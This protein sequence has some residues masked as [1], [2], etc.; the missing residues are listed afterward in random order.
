MPRWLRVLV[1]AAILLGIVL[2]FTNVSHKA[3]WL[4]EGFTAFHVSGYSDS[5]AVEQLVTGKVIANSDL[6]RFQFPNADRSAVDTVKHIAL[7][8][9]ELPPPYFLALRGWVGLFGHTVTS[10]RLFSV[11]LSLL[12]LPAVYWLCRELFPGTWVGAIAMALVAQSPFHLLYAQEA[13][14]YSLWTLLIVLSSAALLRA[15]RKGSAGA[16]AWYG[17]SFAAG[18]YCHLL[19]GLVIIAHTVFLAWHEWG[20][21]GQSLRRGALRKFIGASLLGSL[22]FAPWILFALVNFDNFQMPDQLTDAADAVAQAPSKAGLIKAWVKGWNLTLLDFNLDESGSR[23]GLVGLALLLGG[24]LVWMAIALWRFTLRANGP[25]KQ[26]LLASVGATAAVL[27][28]PDFILGGERSGAFRYWLPAVVS[29]QLIMA[30][31]LTRWLVRGP[32]RWGQLLLVGLLTMGLI[33]N[34]VMVMSW[35]W[36]SKSAANANLELPALV[37]EFRSQDSLAA[38]LSSPK[39]QVETASVLAKVTPQGPLFVSDAFFVFAMAA[40]HAMPTEAQWLLVQPGE[41]PEV[42]E[43]YRTFYLYDPTA[44]LLAQMQAEHDVKQFNA[45]YWQVSRRDSNV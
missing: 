3:F 6:Q 37:R 5:D 7:T 34:G 22:L 28:L 36:W 4:D 42:P 32:R 23:A 45:S 29:M 2:R 21:W 8:A 18:L 24:N 1:I 35:N 25:A 19:H 16:W 43:A 41:L 9:P 13:R 10:L 27:I 40:S 11:A 26:F 33:S 30:F 20:N 15:V 44:A 39:G 31:V 38:S 12:L 14:P 17:L